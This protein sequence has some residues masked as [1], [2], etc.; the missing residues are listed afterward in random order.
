MRFD[1][2][3]TRYGIRSTKKILFVMI[4]FLI[5][6]P[7]LLG[8]IDLS[9][10]IP[11][12]LVFLLFDLRSKYSISALS[13]A[14]I[15]IVLFLLIYTYV[16]AFLTQ[17]I[18]FF[19]LGRIL[20][21]LINMIVIYFCVYHLVYARLISVD[22]IIRYIIVILSIGSFVILA[23]VIFPS[24]QPLMAELVGFNK[25]YLSTRAFGL[26]AGYDTAGY[27][28]ALVSMYS[29]YLYTQYNRRYKYV[30]L[31]SF[32]LSGIAVI[33]ASRSSMA[34]ML[35]LF[36]VVIYYSITTKSASSKRL[37][38]PLLII[39]VP[40]IIYIIPLFVISFGL[41]IDFENIPLLEFIYGTD[42]LSFNK[43]Y[44]STNIG[45]VAQVFLFLPDTIF[46]VIF[47]TAHNVHS[48]IGY[49]KI[50]HIGGIIMMF[51][52]IVV[53]FVLPVRLCFSRG[54]SQIVRIDPNTSK[55]IVLMI[56]F[57]IVMFVGNLK[58]LYFF[59]RGYHELF[60]IIFVSI[61]ALRNSYVDEQNGREYM[62]SL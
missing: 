30:Y 39:T 34:M 42:S 44:A 58:N 35:G 9:V 4:F 25:S 62:R 16:L 17:T 41:D 27:L 12:F 26:T 1:S 22:E 20:R 23:Q 47:G 36:L 53:Y 31:M 6:G 32:V 29:I 50:I 51:L 48:D 7:K 15:L 45:E 10:A 5:Y 46:G 11:F 54:L 61:T 49:V 60:F 13:S 24:I 38:M 19:V 3:K 56:M 2:I 59:T 57:V 40:V 55:Y 37:L 52:T 21:S 18:D 33:Y 8:V 14:S 43:N 28:S